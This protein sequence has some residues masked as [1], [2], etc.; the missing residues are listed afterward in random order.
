MAP[1]ESL[2]ITSPGATLAARHYPGS[3]D[4][5]VLLHGG[6]GMGDY[7][8]SFPEM[9][10]PPHRVVSYDQR[11]CGASSCD[12]TFDVEKQVA[13]L[14]AIRTHLGAKRIHVFGH[15]WGGL[16]GQ[17]YA[18]AHADRVASLVLCCS[19][20]NTGRKVAAMESKC[21][22]ERVIARPK[23]SPVGMAVAGTLMQFPGKLGD[24]GFGYVMK[25]LLPNYVVRPDAVTV[26]FDVTRGSKRA[27]RGTNRSIKA[28]DDDYL[29]HMVLDV[30][31]L[32]VRGEHDVIRETGAVLAERFPRA[33]NVV[34]DAA[35]HFPWLEQP[36]LF[37]TALADF[38]GMAASTVPA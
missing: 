18:K 8:D 6:P 9:L 10:S 17:L 34:I 30:P 4:P 31:V 33:A 1:F 11:G 24:L 37:S 36:K 19:M 29:S 26:R 28:L 13:D 2:R 21:I 12:G 32:I 23:R 16:L 3:G 27:W 35:A 38:Y 20:A 22:A 25:Q 7:F 5:I 14:D 15:S